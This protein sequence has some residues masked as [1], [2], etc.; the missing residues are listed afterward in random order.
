[1]CNINDRCFHEMRKQNEIFNSLRYCK[2]K[3]RDWLILKRIIL[4]DNGGCHNACF[5]QE[6]IT[7]NMVI[8]T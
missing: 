3:A 7:L 8:C 1:M 5:S 4:Q 2:R 6:N